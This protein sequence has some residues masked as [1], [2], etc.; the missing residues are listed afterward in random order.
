MSNNKN[1]SENSIVLVTKVGCPDCMKFE[2]E[3]N[4][5]EKVY[6]PQLIKIL[7]QSFMQ[8]DEMPKLKKIIYNEN[9]N[10]AHQKRQ[11]ILQ[12]Y[13]TDKN[14]GYPL[15]L[16]YIKFKSS[17][18]RQKGRWR[19]YWFEYPVFRTAHNIFYAG[20]I[21]FRFNYCLYLNKKSHHFLDQGNIDLSDSDNNNDH[22]NI[23]FKKYLAFD[24]INWPTIQNNIQKQL[25]AKNKN[26]YVETQSDKS[27]NNPNSREELL[28]VNVNDILQLRE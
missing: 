22:N 8:N 23:Y 2:N 16:F 20:L 19:P 13:A 12:N 1:N 11:Y 17:P 6:Y 24:I 10:D 25:N 3:W 18:E 5:F 27:K 14:D 21:T 7:N 4:I 28:S 9:V 15:L 26:I